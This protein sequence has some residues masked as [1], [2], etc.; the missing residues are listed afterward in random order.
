MVK[1]VSGKRNGG[2][3]MAPLAK[4][5]NRPISGAVSTQT[6][7]LRLDM[8]MFGMKGGV[9]NM[10]GK[11]EAQNTLINGLSAVRVRAG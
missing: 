8:R 3:P 10:M 5:R 2:S 4:L 9:S 11:V 6:H 7:P 1:E